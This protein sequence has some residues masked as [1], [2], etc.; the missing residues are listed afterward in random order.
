[1]TV[2]LFKSDTDIQQDVLKELKW[3][4]RVDPSEVGVQVDQ[5]VVTLTGTIGS[6]AK[7]IAAQE[8]AHR[9]AGVLDVA[10]DLTVKLPSVSE[11]SDQDIAHAVRAALEWDAFVPDARIRSTVSQ[12]WVTLE[13][14][15]EHWSQRLDAERAVDRLTGVKGI[16]NRITVRPTIKADA[17]KIRKG[18]EDA[19]D[20]QAEREAKRIDVQVR[21][22]VVTLTGEVRS[23]AEK[24]AVHNAA[25]FALGVRRVDDRMTVNAY[26]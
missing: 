1:M 8:A 4:P 3:D 26:S 15:V 7:K 13:G 14:E 18:I 10:N 21:D 6:Y 12:G 22:G 16:D 24:H 17:A 20:R 9:V 25:N 2:A 5:G 19:L 23:W 11:R